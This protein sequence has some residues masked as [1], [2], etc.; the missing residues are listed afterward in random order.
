MAEKTGEQVH[1][2]VE[3]GAVETLLSPQVW[4]TLG[5]TLQLCKENLM[6]EAE[7][8][9]ERESIKEGQGSRARKR[10]DGIHAAHW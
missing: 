8:S 2:K 4:H 3:G 9:G 7:N 1:E 6:S 5:Y 10:G